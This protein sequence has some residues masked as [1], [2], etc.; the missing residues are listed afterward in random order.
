LPLTNGLIFDGFIIC[1]KQQLKYPKES[2]H[3]HPVTQQARLEWFLSLAE[4]R[5]VI[6]NWRKKYNQIHPH[7]HLG[8]LS[9]DM[10]ARLW[11]QTEQAVLGSGQATPFL[12]QGLKPKKI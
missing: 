1:C 9:P 8:M 11:P 5:V 4:A 7:S 10:F 2:T 12:R 3:G 6:E